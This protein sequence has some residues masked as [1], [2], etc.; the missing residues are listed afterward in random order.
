MI[1]NMFYT[2]KK[3]RKFEK[4]EDFSFINI[5]LRISRDFEFDYEQNS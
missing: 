1:W 3:I 4:P 5:F 2:K